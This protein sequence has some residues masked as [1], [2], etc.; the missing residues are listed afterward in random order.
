[1]KILLGLY[2]DNYCHVCFMSCDKTVKYD[3]NLLFAM[4][5]LEEIQI[6]HTLYWKV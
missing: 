4:K 1:M 2:I 3:D 6:V 5:L